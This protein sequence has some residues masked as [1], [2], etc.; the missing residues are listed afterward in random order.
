MV[1]ASTMLRGTARRR[2]LARLAPEPPHETDL[3]PL[4]D[5]LIVKA[6]EQDFLAALFSDLK[7]PDWRARLAHRRPG[8][9]KDGLTLGL[10]THDQFNLVLVEACCRMPGQPRFDPRKIKGAGLVLRRVSLHGPQAWMTSGAERRGWLPVGPGAE[11][12]D[13]AGARSFRSGNAAI[14]GL[15]AKARSPAPAEQ[16]FPLFVAPPDVCEALGKTVLY[17]LAPVTSSEQSETPRAPA[18]Y[19]GDAGSLDKHLSPFFKTGD[20]RVMTKGGESLS[21]ALLDELDRRA[22][23]QPQH[24]FALFL[25]QLAMECDAFGPAGAA[26]GLPKLLSRLR[27]EVPAG[28]REDGGSKA[29]D[30]AAFLQAAIAIMLLGAP[31]SAGLRMPFRWPAVD[32]ALAFDLRSAAYAAMANRFAAVSG[33]EAKFEAE[34]RRYHARAFIRAACHGDCPPKLVWSPASAEFR[35]LPWW[36]ASGRNARISLP[37]VTDGDVLK[38]LRPGVSFQLPPKLA[39]FLNQDFSKVAK[40]DQP[41]PPSSSPAIA[42]ICSFSIPIITICAFILFSIILMLLNFVFRWLPFVKICLPVPKG[43]DS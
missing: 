38:S 4:A 7:A 42:W 40:G 9:D 32:A 37:D 15:L 28:P 34:A 22:A 19:A 16:V 33:G 1:V 18:D 13:P 21:P 12:A 20:G 29:M 35:I 43:S 30:G 2:A 23:P 11:L 10:P 26:A 27:I 5:G 31:N 14:D 39:N 25:R 41:R 17:G 3:L 6:S 36:A 24:D 8:R